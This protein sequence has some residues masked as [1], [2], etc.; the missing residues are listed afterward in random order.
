MSQIFLF[1]TVYFGIMIAHYGVICISY[2]IGI[3]FTYA[4]F[5][6]VWTFS[7]VKS[8]YNAYNKIYRYLVSIEP[9]FV[10]FL[11]FK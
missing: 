8:I 9:F 3:S 11:I 6:C 2:R 10:T 4:I 7:V 1:T 5:C